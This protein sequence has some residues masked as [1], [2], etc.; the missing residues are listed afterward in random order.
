MDLASSEHCFPVVCCLY[1]TL[2]SWFMSMHI[3][4]P[5]R[6]RPHEE[7]SHDNMGMRLVASS[8]ATMGGDATCR[9]SAS[10]AGPRLKLL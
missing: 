5:V 9:N 1:D 3:P 7:Q 2:I 8:M 10:D 6:D 4:E